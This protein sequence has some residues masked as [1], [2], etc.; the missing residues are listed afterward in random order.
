MVAFQVQVPGAR[1][2]QELLIILP[3][4]LINHPNPNVF[5][6]PKRKKTQQH[7]STTLQ[8]HTVMLYADQLNTPGSV[9]MSAPVGISG[10]V[11]SNTT[12][13]NDA[14]IDSTNSIDATSY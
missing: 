1:P 5:V 3:P 9:V 10:A 13:F 12:L 14:K 2:E 11:P 4:G 8:H 7:S 6:I